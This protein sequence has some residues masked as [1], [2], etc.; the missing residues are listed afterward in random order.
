MLSL[1]KPF[2]LRAFAPVAW[3]A[4]SS[5]VLHSAP[6]APKGLPAARVQTTSETKSKIA[7]PQATVAATEELIKRL[8]ALSKENKVVFLVEGFPLRK[9]PEL[10]SAV[11]NTAPA[12]IGGVA[13][14]GK[15]AAQVREFDYKPIVLGNVV[16]LQ[17][18]YTD[19]RDMPSVT[20]E[21]CT[22]TL[23]DLERILRG[24]LPK[25]RRNSLFTEQ[26][27]DSLDEEQTQIKL[28]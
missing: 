8:Q 14:A 24:L 16:V 19:P 28:G 17:K 13:V 9:Y 10:G 21:E 22:A 11:G 1:H 2:F 7:P 12:P 26:I 20:S 6:L 5:S 25:V 3:L 18:Q 23:S 4:L 15:V 27:I